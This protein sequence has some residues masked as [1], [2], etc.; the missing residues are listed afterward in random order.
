MNMMTSTVPALAEVVGSINKPD[1]ATDLHARMR[2][3][4]RRGVLI[5]AAWGAVFAAWALLAPIS[6]GIVA[7]GLVK[8]EANRRTVTHRDGGTVSR[9][10]VKEGQL[11]QR[12]DVLVELEDLRVEASVDMLRAQ[13][14]AD[15]LRQS[16]LEAEIAGARR[17]QA[18]KALAAEFSDVKRFAEQ[19]SK[20]QSTF[21]ARQSNVETQI[22]G[23]H[24]QAEDTR[25][26]ISVRLRERENARKAMAL[27]Q[28]EL[29][30]NQKL[31][32]ENYVNRTKVMSLQR[33]VSEYE[34]RQL[35]NE[36]ELSQ[37][38]QRLGALDARM[39]GLR[40]A[41]VQ[42]AAEE[43][44]EVSTRI[45]DEEQ[46]LRA[47]GDDRTRQKIVAP[48]TG[49]LVNLHVNTPGSALGAR[50]PVVDIVPADAPLR[51]E[52]RLPLDAAAEVKPGTAAE[53]RPMTA[54]MRY[55]KLLPATVV[56]VSADALQDE[57]SGTAFVSALV[58]LDPSALAAK[59]AQTL[60][61]G[62]AAEV[63]IK[64]AE[65]TPVGFL[66]EPVS[67]YFRRAFRE[68]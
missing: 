65:R 35:N 7:S 57:R 58:Q 46:R 28:E 15:R 54:Q 36:A 13:L 2:R 21:S 37:A 17:W 66:L 11:V 33:A 51:V 20:E 56:Q 32:Q 6:G 5:I 24:R 14:A 22:E 68:H 67:G 10:L 12:G 4:A 40:D 38:Q 49:R 55:S 25:T 45:S 18:A 26:E 16:R 31:E 62:M 59:G 63:Y 8:V 42:S 23:E 48:E 44:R 34:S 47:S 29:A 43:E 61:P 50:E 52:V 19:A 9:I 41:L 3:I 60:Q 1:R 39:R 30:L 53:V 27:M 64:V